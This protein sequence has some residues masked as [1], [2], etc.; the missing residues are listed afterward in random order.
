MLGPIVVRDT[1]NEAA[2]GWALA[3]LMAGFV[4][5]GLISLRFRPR[6]MLFLGALMLGLTAC[7]PAAIALGDHLVLLLLGAFLHGLGL[8]IYSVNWDLAI[9]Q[10]VAPDKLARVYS[11]DLMGS[12]VAR[13]LGLILTGPVT[14]AVGVTPWLW[15]CVLVMASGS[16][17]AVAVPSVRRL[18]RR[19]AVSDALVSAS[20]TP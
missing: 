5:G 15:V 20:V 2:W 3:T 16:L 17:V 14:A 8:E 19:H 12:F 13:P 18:E 10:N 9:Q 1:W 7:F 11:V 6:R 4:T